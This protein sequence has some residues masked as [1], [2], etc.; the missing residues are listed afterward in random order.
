MRQFTFYKDK[1]GEFRWQLIAT[2]NKIVGASSEGFSSKS[3]VIKNA[4]SNGHNGNGKK[5][6][7]KP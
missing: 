3:A 1:K 7:K 5:G 2:N 4:Q 6:W